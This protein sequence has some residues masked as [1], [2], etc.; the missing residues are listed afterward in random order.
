MISNLDDS[1]IFFSSAEEAK[2][3][4]IAQRISTLCGV[5]EGFK[6]K[7]NAIKENFFDLI[8]I[9]LIILFLF[10]HLS[11]TGAAAAAE[12][13]AIREHKTGAATE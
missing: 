12:T 5:S 8:Y 6:L 10:S 7:V 4:V 3:E 13:H 9:I 1:N 2:E 11:P